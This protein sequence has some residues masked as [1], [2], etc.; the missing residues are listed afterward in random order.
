MKQSPSLPPIA[1]AVVGISDVMTP[2]AMDI[3]RFFVVTPVRLVARIIK[4]ATSRTHPI[5]APH[6][7][8]VMVPGTFLT[9]PFTKR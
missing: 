5:T 7:S 9:A 4:R 8:L 1:H 2:V 6:V 3:I